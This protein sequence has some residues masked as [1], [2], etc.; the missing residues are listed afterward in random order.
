MNVKRAEHGTDCAPVTVLK[1]CLRTLEAAT[2]LGIGKSTLEAMR[3]EGDGP[4]F[5]RAGKVVLYPLTS[6][7]D[8]VDSQPRFRSTA[9]ADQNRNAT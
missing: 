9:E 5:I 3:Y 7:N 6:L 4:E 2:F 8:W 1:A